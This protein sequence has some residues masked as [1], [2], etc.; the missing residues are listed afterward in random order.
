MIRIATFLLLTLMAWGAAG[1]ADL[2]TLI[3]E[4]NAAFERMDYDKALDLYEDGL[5]AASDE[6]VLF[7]NKGNVLFRQEKYAEAV[8]AWSVAIK[9]KPRPILLKNIY[10]NSGN[11][12][13]RVAEEKGLESDDV[14][15]LKGVLGEYEKAFDMYRK[16]L[17]LERRIGVSRGYDIHAAGVPA[18]RNWALA[19]EGWTR[20]WEKIRTL[21]KKDLK[22]EDGVQQIL[23][24]QK[25]LLPKLE[26]IYLGSFSED[27]L[28]FN[29]KTLSQFQ[30]DFRDDVYHLREVAQKDIERIDVEIENHKSAKQQPAPPGQPAPPAPAPDQP[31]PELE[32]LEK[33]K[34]N[35]EKILEAVTQAIGLEE[36]IVD[37]FNRSEVLQSWKHSREMIALLRGLNDYLKK[38]DPAFRVYESLLRDLMEADLLVDRS[39]RMEFASEKGSWEDVK[40]RLLIL[41]ARKTEVASVQAAGVN[42]YLKQYEEEIRKQKERAAPPAPGP[43][44]PTAPGAPAA[45]PPAPN[46]M[47]DF[48]KS[49]HF[50]IMIASVADVSERNEALRAA[51]SE[52]SANLD[53]GEA[54]DVDLDEQVR[55]GSDAFVRYQH[56]QTDVIKLF[57]TLIKE[58]ESLQD[59]LARLTA[60]PPDK[61]ENTYTEALGLSDVLLFKYRILIQALSN[62]SEEALAPLRE[63]APDLLESLE[64]AWEAM[65]AGRKAEWAA[66]DDAAGLMA[67]ASNFRMELLKNL[68]ALAPDLAISHY[69][70]RVTALQNQVVE[71]LPSSADNHASIRTAYDRTSRLMAELDAL[72]AQFFRQIRA[73]VDANPD[74]EKK[75][76][77]AALLRKRERSRQL[78]ARALAGGRDAGLLMESG[79]FMK[80]DLL[81]RD[82]LP[83]V[84]KSHMAFL[85]KPDK[86]IPAVET[87]IK[88]QKALEEQSR[89]G[90]AIESEEGNSRAV[91]G[92]AAANQAD[93]MELAGEAIRMIREDI[94]KAGQQAGGPQAPILGPPMTQPP[95]QCPMNQPADPEK[96][97]EAVTHIQDALAEAQKI[98]SF[99]DVAEFHNTGEKHARVIELLE[100]ALEALKSKQQPPQDQKGDQEKKGDQGQDQNKNGQQPKPSRPMELTPEQAR[101]LL[102]RLNKSDERDRGKKENVKGKTTPNTPRPW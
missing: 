77:L 93:V 35:S 26:A 49:S 1:A 19:R 4:G 82:I 51:L 96:M 44:A 62:G 24:A 81:L 98:R 5:A 31:D 58:S 87:S 91:A 8:E 27:A 68:L 9:N 73:V 78:L 94:E 11:A 99:L 53:A 60:S 3:D 46:P 75:E 89:S 43:A 21:E 37:G 69:Y 7:Y 79:E 90:S 17:E 18:R 64:S 42:A 14:E 72:L 102:N 76:A 52:I 83:V 30:L 12:H 6:P 41:A 20:T 80:T 74:P 92:Y 71:L 56:L 16:S 57:S 39:G 13:F 59:D 28:K 47:A 66:P 86:A 61:L 29:L 10:F 100:K 85:H 34:E 50:E 70:E 84:E 97:E 2:E 88:W 23:E 65:D 25:A 54:A 33:E 101:D 67:V 15:A 32:K 22:L 38:A 36:W 63:A 55:A 45:P 48:M 40:S 95:P